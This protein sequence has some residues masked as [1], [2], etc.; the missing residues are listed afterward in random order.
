MDHI[1]GSVDDRWRNK[2]AHDAANEETETDFADWW[3]NTRHDSASFG[4]GNGGIIRVLD[5]KIESYI[6]SRERPGEICWSLV[7]SGQTPKYEWDSYSSRETQTI[8]V[9]DSND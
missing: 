4:D 6:V 7:S 5:S 2:Q 1:D 8:S 9:P 3:R